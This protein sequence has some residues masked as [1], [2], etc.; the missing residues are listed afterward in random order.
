NTAFD[1]LIDYYDRFGTLPAPETSDA[2]RESVIIAEPAPSA[3]N[4]GSRKRSYVFDTVPATDRDVLRAT[5]LWA[6]IVAAIVIGVAAYVALPP[7]A[8]DEPP[9]SAN[10]AA[11]APSVEPTQTPPGETK[12]SD[13]K[14]SR[15][16]RD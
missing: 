4:R 11:L 1:R 10:P 3:D 8:G 7:N 5:L 15:L 2:T 13:L 12:P 14:P 9:D 6:T 16:K